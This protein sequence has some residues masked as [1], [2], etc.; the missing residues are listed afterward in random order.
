MLTLEKEGFRN[1]T[2]HTTNLKTPWAAKKSTTF[3]AEA[4]DYTDNQEEVSSISDVQ[5]NLDFEA[6]IC[7]I[8][9]GGIFYSNIVEL[10]SIYYM[11]T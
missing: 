5:S 9:I 4:T 7:H 2:Q 8:V 1:T 3:Y 10:N 6:L 11:C